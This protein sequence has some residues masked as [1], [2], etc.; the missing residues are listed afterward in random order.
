MIKLQAVSNDNTRHKLLSEAKYIHIYINKNKYKAI[1]E[2][3]IHE[4]TIKEFG[5]SRDNNFARDILIYTLKQAFLF[6]NV[7]I[8]VGSCYWIGAIEM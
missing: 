5:L 2:N 4:N 1:H 3:I 7:G 8:F 6:Q